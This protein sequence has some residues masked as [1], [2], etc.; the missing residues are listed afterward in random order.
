MDQIGRRA[1]IK[2]AVKTA[3]VVTAAGG[4]VLL[5][6]C[7]SA[8]E[9]DLL[10]SGGTVYDGTGGPPVRADVGIAGNSI[11]LVGKIPSSRARSVI[12]ADGLAVSPGFIDVHE[13]TSTELL[14]NP[15]AESAVR[16]GVTTLVS[17]NCGDSPFPL[18]EAMFDEA[19]KS[20]LEDFGLEMTWRDARGFFGR[21]EKSG[22][23][24]NY[25]SFVGQGTVRAA[26]MGYG[27]R[28]ATAAELER[29]KTLV[30]ESMEGGTLGLSSGLEYSP[31]SFASTEEIIELCRVAVRSGGVYAT[32]MRDEEEGILEAVDEAIRIARETPVRL[33]ISH[34]KIGYPKN[35][36]KFDDLL[37]RVDRANAAGVNL[38][39][40]RYPYVAWATGLNMF[41][42]LWAREGPSQDFIARLKDASLQARLKAAVAEKE[43]DLGSWDKVLISNVATDKNRRFEGTNILEASRAAG[44][45]PY[46]FMRT[47]L[48]EEDGRVGMITFG[49]SE[50]HLRRL[51]AHPL[52]GVGSDGQAVAPYGPLSRGKPHPRFYGTF[53]RVLGRYVRE[54]KVA[55][56]EEMIRKMTSMPAGHLGFLRRGVLKTGW[57]ADLVV[58]DPARVIDRATWTDPARYPEGIECVVVNGAVVVEKGDHT[59]RLPG[60]VLKRNLR[61][62]VA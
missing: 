52:V 58:F 18:T 26:A 11:K 32:H 38:R 36:Y 50:D 43:K 2:G 42:P 33:Q 20:L 12:K 34:L 30:R 54:E 13:H 4:G 47:L 7:T 53:A 16:Q 62:V 6:G 28:P 44:L 40:D 49:M 1:F 57:A 3:A 51:L 8:K 14:V 37:S 19:A 39:C 48:I 9:Y 59:G 25:A 21:L 45:E 23:A 24:L 27:N 35:W 60:R 41:F 31:G 22:A 46:E 10:V 55:P 29:M 56:L 15:K 5:K 61:G 17:G